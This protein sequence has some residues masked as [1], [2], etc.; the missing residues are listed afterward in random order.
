MRSQ[1]EGLA[2]IIGAAHVNFDLKIKPF[3]SKLPVQ[4]IPTCE[5]A[6]QNL[7]EIN[8]S[9]NTIV[10]S[11]GKK[12]VKASIYLKKKFKKKVF[13]IHIQDPKSQR[14]KFDLIICPEHDKLNSPNSISTQLALHNIEFNK[15]LKNQDTINFIIGGKNK[16]FNFHNETQLKIINEINLLAKNYKVNVIPSRRTPSELINKIIEIK[17]NNLFIF[18]ELFSPKKYGDL[19]SS[20]SIQI[21]TWDSISMISESISSGIG[22][23]IYKFEENK[24]PERYNLFLQ[25]LINNNYA[26]FFD[27]ILKPFEVNIDAYN[28]QLRTKILNKIK[29]NLWFQNYA[30]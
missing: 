3:F 14:S 12:S 15:L 11:C 13:N 28:D 21:V 27:E 8:I 6:Y 17:N 5:L 22:T 20:G 1:I 26:K 2:K 4:L 7:S 19:L 18:E 25:S 29:S 24:L 16:Y 10:I 9:N 30:S 23:Y